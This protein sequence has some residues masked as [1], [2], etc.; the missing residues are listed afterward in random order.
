MERLDA[1]KIRHAE[2]VMTKFSHRAEEVANL[3]FGDHCKIE[4]HGDTYLSND[5]ETVTHYY[6]DG[7]D[8]EPYDN[9]SVEF[10]FNWLNMSFEELKEL[11]P[12]YW[13]EVHRIQIE[14][15]KRKR[16]EE[17][18][19]RIK[20]EEKERQEYERLKAKFEEENHE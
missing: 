20:E 13:E 1:Q 7:Y 15:E 9:C 19:K 4:T 14:E 3:M 10:P 6:W 18:T 2:E 8:A 5:G 16:K 11:K 17:E 12:K